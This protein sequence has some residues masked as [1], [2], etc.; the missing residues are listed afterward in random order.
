MLLIALRA[1]AFLQAIPL[2]LYAYDGPASLRRFD[3]AEPLL[4]L[5]DRRG[6]LAGACP[7]RIVAWRA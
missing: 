4:V 2:D 7:G 3:Q 1:R 5:L 6:R